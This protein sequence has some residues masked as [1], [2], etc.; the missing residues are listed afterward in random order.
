[1]MS[2]AFSARAAAVAALVPAAIGFS[3]SL[4]EFHGVTVWGCTLILYYAIQYSVLLP[5]NTPMSMIAFST[6]TF[7][8]KEMLGVGAPLIIILM[9]LTMVFIKTYWHWMGLV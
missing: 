4:A 8:A 2:L 3:Q 6:N 9:L 1:M 5:V 7:T